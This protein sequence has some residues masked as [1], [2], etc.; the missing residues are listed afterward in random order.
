MNSETKMWEKDINKLIKKGKLKDLENYKKI[1]NGT[2]GV[3]DSV[4]AEYIQKCDDAINEINSK[5]QEPE[6]QEV[7][8]EVQEAEQQEQTIDASNV[9]VGENTKHSKQKK[10]TLKKAL[11]TA[12]IIGVIALA[13]PGVSRLSS[14]IGNSCAPKGN[15]DDN[16]KQEQMLDEIKDTLN[17]D[18][19]NTEV[20]ITNID[21]F[22][23]ESMSKG[24]K[25]DANNLA[26]D[27]ESFVDFYVALNIDEIGPGYLA[28]LYQSD[29]KSYLDVFNNYVRWAMNITDEAMMASAE[30]PYDIMPLVANK[31]EA[32]VL[33][34][35]FN[36]LAQMHDNGLA[37][38]KE[39]L[40]TNASD[41][42]AILNEVLLDENSASYSTPSKVLLA[43][44]AMN[45]D[46]LLINYEDIIIVDNDIRMVIYEDAEIR[47]SMTLRDIIAEGKTLSDEDLRL[48]FN[49]SEK[50]QSAVEFGLQLEK[51]FD[52]VVILYNTA[53]FDYSKE[54]SIDEVIERLVKEVDFS[55]YKA[56]QE[57]TEY[58]DITYD[59]NHPAIV[60]PED[61][62]VITDGDNDYYIEKDELDKHGVDT[63]N[64]TP[65]QVKD[66]YESKVEEKVEE[67]LKDDKTFEDNNGNV[68]E[69]GKDAVD[70]ATEY[71]NGWTA[72]SKQGA[73][74]GN[75]LAT[76]NATTNGSEG[77]KAG[78]A[79]GY[80]DSYES[81]KAKRLAAEKQTS[82][83]IEKVDPIVQDTEVIEE[84]T[85]NS[86]EVITTPIE[87]EKPVDIIV[88][89]I[90]TPVVPLPEVKEETTTT[91]IEEEVIEE[92]ILE[93]PSY[94]SE[95]TVEVIEEGVLTSEE[96]T[97]TYEASVTGMSYDELYNLYYQYLYG[98]DSN[99]I[100]QTTEKTK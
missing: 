50:N 40:K 5:N 96:T 6:V 70:Y 56:N 38:N 34:S 73:I 42:K 99:S 39:A 74:D 94:N 13:I 4:K 28:K 77:Y 85:K 81:A 22:I 63:T 75:A 9:T 2:S 98:T 61:S 57:Y 54:T 86:D 83:T 59:I 23:T 18:V 25:L 7:E 67:E 31:E 26:G 55:F 8:Q 92:G 53:G 16:K 93:I 21:N 46:A 69:E 43:Y 32:Q 65:E 66:E 45:A 47:C 87:S 80:N 33:Q 36:L 14:C 51:K 64:K 58:N 48:L 62:V 91:I 68:L 88:S 29:N 24:L 35:A 78:Y 37:G 3:D 97:T 100:E 52:Q 71:S 90:E 44:A 41:F 82:T 84:G 49:A 12:G 89:P 20:M 72:G 15:E 79:V 30:D 1:I 19:E 27:M 60:I 17:F 95:T 11:A 76:K 10:G